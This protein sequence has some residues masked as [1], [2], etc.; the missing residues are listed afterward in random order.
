MNEE[1][2]EVAEESQIDEVQ[3][4]PEQEQPQEQMAD[5]PDWLP[6]KFNSEEDFAKSYE[7][8][9]RR[10]H[11]RSEN[12]REEIMQELAEEAAGDVPVSPADYQ[13]SL[14]D[15]TGEEVEIDSEDNMLQ[16]FQ[17]KAHD[18]GLSQEQFNEIVAEYTQQNVMTGPN[19]NEESEILGEHAERRL[20]RVDSW[21]SANMS[22][23]A[24]NMF[25]E[26]PA[27]AGMVHFF[28]ELM[29]VSGQPRFNMVSETQFQES[30]TQDDLRAAQNDPGYWR[31]KDPAAIAKVQAISRSLAMKKHG[32]LEIS[33]MQQCELTN[34]NLSV[35][36][37][38]LEGPKADIAALTDNCI[39][40]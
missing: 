9:E 4:Q 13:L 20:E 18:L 8:L 2:Q 7:H 30:V 11:E 6:S 29:E 19:W 12:F 38:L 39:Y 27:S 10:L 15:E 17:G 37:G 28:E 26:L 35:R 3:V 32:T 34:R 24:Y 22:D 33:Q 14:V 36:V 21:V 5:R 25:A 23:A 1:L 40:M 31:D 16:W